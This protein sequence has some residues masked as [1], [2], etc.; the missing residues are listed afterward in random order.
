MKWSSSGNIEDRPA[1][2]GVGYE[3][4]EESRMRASVFGCVMLLFT[5]MG[6]KEGS[7]GRTLE[8]F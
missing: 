8:S 4:K 5:K 2:L 1:G 7:L 6:N 3:Q